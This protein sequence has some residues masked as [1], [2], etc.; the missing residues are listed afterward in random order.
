MIQNLF[1]ALKKRLETIE[2]LKV[3]R[4]SASLLDKGNDEPLH[5]VPSAHIQFAQIE[6]VTMTHKLQQSNVLLIVYVACENY[7]DNE[8]VEAM[9]KVID[10]AEA[11]HRVLHLFAA[12]LSYLTGNPADEFVL[13]NAL[14][15]QRIVVDN[16]PTNID[17]TELHY[18][19]I[20]Y[21]T[22]NVPICTEVS[23]I[24]VNINPTYTP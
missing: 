7:N 23:P 3:Y 20:A 5:V 11:V 18:K 8:S 19:C 24:T 13:F 17:I 9:T 1:F 21:D 6:T 14:H 12:Q 22:D 16:D 10:Y 2:G 15:R 4:Y